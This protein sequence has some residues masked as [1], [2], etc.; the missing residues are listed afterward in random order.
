VRYW[1]SSKCLSAH[2]VGFWVVFDIASTLLI[3]H[4]SGLH[5]ELNPLMAA[6]IDA[7]SAVFAVFKLSAGFTYSSSTPASRGWLTLSSPPA[8]CSPSFS[9][10][11]TSPPSSGFSDTS[12]YARDGLGGA[13]RVH[14]RSCVDHD[15]GTIQNG[16]VRESLL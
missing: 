5:L 12:P 11:G 3:V 16:F 13:S 14:T 10:R 2:F 6:L 9:S 4:L 15:G 8:R 1:F 7:H